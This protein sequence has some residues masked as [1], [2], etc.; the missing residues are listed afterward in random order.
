MTRRKRF[1]ATRSI[2]PNWY[3][4]GC[5]LYLGARMWMASVSIRTEPKNH[6]DSQ[7]A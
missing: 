2:A 4:F 7:G 5:S 6:T 1:Y 3:Y